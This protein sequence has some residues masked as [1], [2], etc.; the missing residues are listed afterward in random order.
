MAGIEERPFPPGRYSVVVVGSGP[1]GLQ[2]S[3]FLKK[4]GIDHAV[5]SKDEAAGGMFRRFPIFD[6]LI[7]WTKLNAPFE[8]GSR[9]YEWYDW[10][11][12]L[13]DDPSD[14]V[15]V[16]EFMDGTSEFPSRAEMESALAAFSDRNKIAVRYECEWVGSEKAGDDFVI[17]TADG[18]YAAP[19]V[20]IAVGMTEPWKP[21]IPGIEHVPHYMSLKPASEYKGKRIYLMG[22][23]ASAFEVADGLLHLARQIVLSSPHGARPS[24]IEHSLGGVR[25][26]YMQPMEDDAFG[27]GTVQLLDASTDKFEKTD[28]GFIVHVTGTTKHFERSLIFDEA[29]SAT[30]VSA[31]LV[32]LSD[33]GVETFYK[34]GRLPA[35]NAFW[36]SAT[37]PGV[38][39]AGSITQGAHGLRKNSG[40]AA[41]HGVRYNARIMTNHIAETRFGVEVKRPLLSADEVVPFL[42]REITHAPELWNQRSYLGRA[43]LFDEQ[44]GIVDEGIVPLTHFVDGSGPPGIAV[45]IDFDEEGDTRPLVY[46]RTG[47]KVDERKLD[48]EPFLNFE[49]KEHEA[50]LRDCL[51]DLL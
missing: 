48:P 16:D 33:V 19:V 5:I 6:R 37:A 29:I 12:L 15:G 10:N 32:D 18:N 30:G 40:A 43:V 22:K 38:Y 41:V 46:V 14:F 11:S 27:G 28:E 7:S 49:T 1:G 31:P 23:G 26:R 9:E 21:N 20:I 3:Y 36:E 35:Q 24:V 17:K 42:L 4:L 50:Q 51:Q 39:F 44:R 45:A 2:T 25:A 8:R 47:P 13:V 34:G